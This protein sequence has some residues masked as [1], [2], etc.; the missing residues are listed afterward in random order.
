MSSINILGTYSGI[1]MSTVEK[2]ME[3]ERLPLAGLTKKKTT[4]SEVQNAWRDVNTRLKSLYDKLD[5][6]KNPD[7]FQSKSATSTDPGVVTINPGTQAIPGQYTVHV[8]TLATSTRVVGTK[9]PVESPEVSMGFTGSILV[10]NEEGNS[11]QVDVTEQDT[12]KSVMEK[13]NSS[14]SDTGV[15][16]SLIDGRLVLEDSRTG[17]RTIQLEALAGSETLLQ[18]LGLDG[19]RTEQVGINAQFEINGVFV[20]RGENTIVDV[21]PDLT[22][23][24]KK[25]HEIGA[26]ET[27][28]VALNLA[29]GEKAIREFVDQYNSTMTFIE[30]KMAPGTVEN[31]SSR[32]ILAG[33]GTLQRLQASLRYQVTSGLNNP[34]NSTLKDLS[35]LGVT[36]VDRYGKL[37]FDESN[38]RDEM[39][40][41]P[42]NIA[43]F[44]FGETSDGTTVGFVPRINE[45]I[46]S[47]I[48]TKSG[49][50]K[51]KT[52]SMER[53]LKDLNRQIENFNERIEKKEQYYIKM[54]SALDVA[55]MKA[56]SQMQWLAGQLSALNS[57]NTGNGM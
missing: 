9:V 43:G 11:H 23:E 14:T 30:S 1:D 47:F 52:D 26:F 45:T 22:L 51:G 42:R 48:S 12:L 5:L 56:E 27:I 19:G 35:S 31:P 20:E 21:V 3:V 41:D 50:I 57:Q 38:F 13:L 55:M 8:R 10:S 15:R 36:T 4:L 53:S 54:F 25:T 32:G 49:I 18:N 37:T 28:T 39:A 33:D 6:L 34:E 17:A 24:L 46:D 44:F 16:A 29:K 40:K 7:L 2:L